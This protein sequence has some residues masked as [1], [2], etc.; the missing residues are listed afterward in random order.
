MK[1]V[2]VC[3]LALWKYLQFTNALRLF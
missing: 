3:W 2:C 1:I